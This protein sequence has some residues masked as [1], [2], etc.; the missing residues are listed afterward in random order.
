MFE[1]HLLAFASCSCAETCGSS[2]WMA[3]TRRSSRSVHLYGCHRLVTLL[4]TDWLERRNGNSKSRRVG[5]G[6]AQTSMLSTKTFFVALLLASCTALLPLYAQNPFPL[7]VTK[8]GDNETSRAAVFLP[9]LTHSNLTYS[10]HNARNFST[11]CPVELNATTL[12]PVTLGNLHKPEDFVCYYEALKTFYNASSNAFG[13]QPGEHVTVDPQPVEPDEY[14]NHTNVPYDWRMPM[15]GLSAFYTI[16]KAHIETIYEEHNQLPIALVGPS[17]GAEV[18]ISFLHRMEQ[19]WKDKYVKWFIAQ[20]PVWSG[21]PLA[22]EGFIS[23]VI[24]PET[25]STFAALNRI[26]STSVDVAFQVF[27]QP[28]TTN[29]TYNSTK[30]LVKTPARS[31][32]AFDAAQLLVDLG[33]DD[34]V[35]A[36][37]A[38]QAGKDLADLKHPGVNTF[39]IHG[40]ELPTPGETDLLSVCCAITMYA[41]DVFIYDKEFVPDRFVV[42]KSPSKVETTEGDG[43]VPMISAIRGWYDWKDAMAKDGYTLLYKAYPKQFHGQCSDTCAQDWYNLIATGQVPDGAWSNQ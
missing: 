15:D 21:A 30:V 35:D 16:L 17:W 39:V 40:T 42:P 37:Q 18:G 8:F 4:K 34:R 13:S 14:F 9:G 27:P 25:P 36:L 12:W 31:Y 24:L 26:L 1:R 22:F 20:S 23:G 6:I 41:L 33:F 32:T 29:N 38:V 2:L 10:L 5:L 43:Y 19:A 7:K 11:G 3:S 28:G